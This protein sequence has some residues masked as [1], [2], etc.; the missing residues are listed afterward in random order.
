MNVHYLQKDRTVSVY[1]KKYFKKFVSEN[2]RIHSFAHS[3]IN[4]MDINV[5]VTHL[6]V[7]KSD[8]VAFL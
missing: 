1:F 4:M 3:D 5:T 8:F 6:G 7:Q 2:F